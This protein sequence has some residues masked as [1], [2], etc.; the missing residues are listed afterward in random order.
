MTFAKCVSVVKFGSFNKNNNKKIVRVRLNLNYGQNA[1]M[2]VMC[3]WSKIE[4]ANV[5]A[6]QKFVGN[7][8]LDLISSELEI[9]HMLNGTLPKLNTENWDLDLFR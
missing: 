9:S 1:N 6:R 7:H 2:H 5:R 8:S 4:C 3:V